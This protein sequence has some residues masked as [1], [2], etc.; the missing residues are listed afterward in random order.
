MSII[1]ALKSWVKTLDHE[2]SALKLQNPLI[3]SSIYKLSCCKKS[4]HIYEILNENDTQPSCKVKWNNLFELEENEWKTIYKIPFKMTKNSKLQWFQYRLINNILATNSFLYK[5]KKIDTKMCTF[6]RIEEETLVH[7]FWECSNVQSF[8]DTFET[9][10]QEHTNLQL[11]IT[12]KNFLLR[13]LDF[14]KITHNTI[15]LWLKYYIY[16]PRDAQK[17]Y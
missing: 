6:C 1:Q 3:L 4:K 13:I 14:K 8:L 11:P 2:M 15:F 5:I 9:Y 16:T 10:V 7:I 17:R 12:K